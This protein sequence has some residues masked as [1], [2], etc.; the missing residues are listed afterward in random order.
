MLTLVRLIFSNV[1]VLCHCHATEFV[2]IFLYFCPL[3]QSHFFGSIFVV[4]A[5]DFTI[6]Y[7][8]SLCYL[9]NCRFILPTKLTRDTPCHKIH[10]GLVIINLIANSTRQAEFKFPEDDDVT[11]LWN[12][13]NYL[14][15]YMSQHTKIFSSAAVRTSNHVTYLLDSLVAVKVK[16]T[17]QH[18]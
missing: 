3:Y 1:F 5:S 15:V 16:I 14:P 7:F 13:V 4:I 11:F 2:S 17:P 18:G 6:E 10:W 9:E 12:V 8:L